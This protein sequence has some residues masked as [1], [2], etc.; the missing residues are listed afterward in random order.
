MSMKAYS[1][2]SSDPF[3]QAT[4]LLTSCAM[5]IHVRLLGMYLVQP[6][7]YP[8]VVCAQ[9]STA[10]YAWPT[11]DEGMS[12]P[13]SRC[14][15]GR[16]SADVNDQSRMASSIA[17]PSITEPVALPHSASV[18]ARGAKLGGSELSAGREGSRELL[19][20]M[21]TRSTTSSMFS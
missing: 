19:S 5:T 10:K 7:L 14:Q 4:A 9:H 6:V 2:S 3:L 20:N 13:V 15:S 21:K 18:P 1:C 11:A 17:A 8:P 12:H 16:T